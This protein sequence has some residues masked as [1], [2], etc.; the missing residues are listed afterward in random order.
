MPN[1][2]EGIIWSNIG[3]AILLTSAISL[4]QCEFLT[5]LFNLTK[6]IKV[7]VIW[8]L[9]AL[10]GSIVLK[11][12]VL[13]HLLLVIAPINPLRHHPE[14]VRV[15]TIFH[16][17]FYTHQWII[18]NLRWEETKKNVLIHHMAC[19]CKCSRDT[20]LGPF[21]TLIHIINF[22]ILAFIRLVII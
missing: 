13:K 21:I 4:T 1:I 8:P 6:S 3:R 12:R 19:H 9:L 20:K 17:F 7:K 16:F 18:M 11:I 2:R 22:K 15:F 5:F 10:V 14:E